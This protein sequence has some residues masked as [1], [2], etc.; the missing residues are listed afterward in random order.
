MLKRKK[1]PKSNYYFDSFPI[2]A[3]SSVECGE[4]I[5]NFVKEFDASK[6][7]QLKT[8]VHLIEHQADEVKHAVTARLL[9][10]FMTPID[11]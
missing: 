8:N 11:R 10:E 4:M 1:E 2:L 7:E 3:H 5:L 6:L 9:T